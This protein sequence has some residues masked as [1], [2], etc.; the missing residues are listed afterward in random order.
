MKIEYVANGVPDCP[1]IHLYAFNTIEVGLLRDRVGALISGETR[2]VSLQD[3]VWI[4]P[5]DGCTLTMCR[6][7]RNQGIIETDP[8]KFECVL[9]SAGWRNVEGWLDPFRDSDFR[10]FQWLSRLGTV[11]LV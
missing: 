9:S 2:F 3:E 10:G 8:R 5:V 1:L 4:E 11:S 7:K 6:G